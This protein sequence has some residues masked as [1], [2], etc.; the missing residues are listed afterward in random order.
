M[1]SKSDE[2]NVDDNPH[3]IDS[4]KAI[5]NGWVSQLVIAL[6]KKLS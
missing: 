5:I 1:N 4:I 2:M 6:N 3:N